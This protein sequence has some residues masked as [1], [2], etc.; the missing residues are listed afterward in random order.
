M[1]RT[2]S[3]LITFTSFETRFDYLKL[4]GEVGGK[5]FGFDRWMNQRFYTSS[6]WQRIRSHVIARDDACD[7]AVSGMGIFDTI[8]I[9]H[10]NPVSQD[11]IL[12]S[13]KTLLDIEYLVCTSRSTHLA[14][15]FGN[16]DN[17]LVTPIT[18]KPKD[19]RL[20]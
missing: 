4:S 16:K 17:L 8:Y 6:E 20:W 5:T 2:Y 19:T 18:R 1:I 12:N 15:H 13:S 14:I 3:D 10:M 9:H 11:N 7:L